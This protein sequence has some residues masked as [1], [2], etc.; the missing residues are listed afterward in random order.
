MSRMFTFATFSRAYSRHWD[1]GAFLGHIF[2][3]FEKGHSVGLQ[4][5]T[6]VILTIS[7]ENIF[8]KSHTTEV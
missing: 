6:D 7:N 5:L 8:P 1:T 3:F 2:F 4:P